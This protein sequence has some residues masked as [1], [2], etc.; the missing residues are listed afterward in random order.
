MQCRKGDAAGLIEYTNQF[1][2]SLK[3]RITHFL[4]QKLNPYGKLLQTEKTLRT[5]AHDFLSNCLYV[6]LLRTVTWALMSWYWTLI[7][8]PEQLV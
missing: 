8:A 1:I 4:A 6:A 3:V 5:T 2:Y 7:L